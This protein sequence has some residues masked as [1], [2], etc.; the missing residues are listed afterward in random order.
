MPSAV[1]VLV[2]K[3]TPSTRYNIGTLTEIVPFVAT[4]T[5]HS[6]AQLVFHGP[7]NE[8]AH[9]TDATLPGCKLVQTNTPFW[10]K[11]LMTGNWAM[12]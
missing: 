10:L 2:V 8:E 4:V 11:E 3:A 9:C 5:A 1:V 7:D 6:P 12:A